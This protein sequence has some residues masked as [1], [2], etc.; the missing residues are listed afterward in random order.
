MASNIKYIILLVGDVWLL[1]WNLV[2][3]IVVIV[4]GVSIYGVDSGILFNYRDV[5]GEEVGV[6]LVSCF[7]RYVVWMVFLGLFG[8]IVKI[9]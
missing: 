4:V 7:W 2:D 9:S 1:L 5:R 3:L 8:F 6:F